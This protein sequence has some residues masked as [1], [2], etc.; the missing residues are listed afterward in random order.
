MFERDLAQLAEWQK[1]RGNRMGKTHFNFD[2]VGRELW[3]N[4]LTETLAD[5]PEFQWLYIE[6]LA[7]A[8]AP[9]IKAWVAEIIAEYRPNVYHTALIMQDAF[10]GL[11]TV[12][13][14]LYSDE[15]PVWGN[16]EGYNVFTR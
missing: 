13:I 10:T 4:W 8:D 12:A 7:E 9:K 16:R 1:A 5:W 3:H 11:N 15:I 14:E 6:K 2:G